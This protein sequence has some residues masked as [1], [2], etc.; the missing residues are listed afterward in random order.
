MKILVK[1]YIFDLPPGFEDAEPELP[2]GATVSDVLEECFK[3]ILQRR[4]QWI[5]MS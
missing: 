1:F 4:S 3:L 5:K 2:D